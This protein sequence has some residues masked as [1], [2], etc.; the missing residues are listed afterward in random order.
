MVES[1]PESRPVKIDRR[2]ARRFLLSAHGLR[3]PRAHS[4]KAGVLTYLR[5][6]RAV[7]FDPIDIV[8]RN[9]DLVF[10]SRVV[11]YRAEMLDELLYQDRLIWDGWDKMATLIPVE[12]WPYFSRRRSRMEDRFGVPSE[13]VMQLE[14]KIREAIREEGPHS[15]L[16]FDFDQKTD[17]AWGPTRAARAALEGLY[18]MGRLG[19]H[20]RVGSRRYFDLIER[21]LPIEIL[22]TTEPHPEEEEYQ[23]WHLL[24]RV[25]SLK[26]AHPHA[27]VHWSGIEGV[28]TARRRKLLKDLAGEG[29]LLPVMIEGVDKGEFYLH[30]RDAE[31]LTAVRNEVGQV[32]RAAVIAPLDNLLWDRQA[33]GWIFGFEYVWEVYKPKQDREYGYYVLPV[34]YD[35][36]FVGRFE[37]RF[38][39]GSRTLEIKNWWWEDGIQPDQAMREALR[40]CLA[41]FQDYL[42]AE[43]FSLPSALSGRA[44]LAWLK[45]LLD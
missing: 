45:P 16:D 3:P 22:E 40:S 32:E 38:D 19:V 44:D 4:G 17:W 1:Q 29:K 28:K 31:I 6:V 11:D 5:D 41:D 9:P 23:R 33:L 35:D 10:Q 37:P 30:H 27:G 43:S 8:G 39:R 13:V 18:R 12:D 14:P 2:S 21:L 34:L 24:R 42:Q 36:R 26:L 20:H 25:S 7:Q 15:S